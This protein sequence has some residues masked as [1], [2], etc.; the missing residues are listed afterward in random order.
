MKDMNKHPI[1]VISGGREQNP[2]IVPNYPFRELVTTDYNN[3]HVYVNTT[4]V[5]I[6]FTIPNVKAQNFVYLQHQIRCIEVKV[7]TP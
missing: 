5:T 6:I 7:P 3:T 1:I 4:S 2:A